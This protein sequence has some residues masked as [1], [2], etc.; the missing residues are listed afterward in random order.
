MLSHKSDFELKLRQSSHRKSSMC[1][2]F[3]AKRMQQKKGHV[4]PIF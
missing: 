2:K 4:D 3:W 1:I